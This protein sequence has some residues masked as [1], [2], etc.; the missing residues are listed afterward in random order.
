MIR[1]DDP[2]LSTTELQ[3]SRTRKMT[4]I[5]A[6]VEGETAVR[7]GHVN[8]SVSDLERSLTFYRDALNMKITKR[9]GTEAAFLAFHNYHHDLC[10]NTWN[11]KGGMPRPEGTT[12]LFHFAVTYQ[13]L[14]AL[15]AACQ[16]V[17]AA[18]VHIDDV[19]DHGTSLS[20]YVRDPDQNGVELNWD[21]QA[22]SWRSAD[23]SLRMGHRR[24]SLDQLL[25]T[26]D[27]QSS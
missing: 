14:D 16:R 25:G 21:R 17:L 9:I 18:G 27:P 23:G 10:I 13:A 1:R 3:L 19:V 7:I 22:E 4:T 2:A 8:L 24:I 20:V 11:S 5:P 15:Q 12:G 6:P 26:T